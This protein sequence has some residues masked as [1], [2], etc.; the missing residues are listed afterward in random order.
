MSPSAAVSVRAN[1]DCEVCYTLS[2]EGVGGQ[3]PYTFDWQDGSHDAERTICPDQFGGALTLVVRD[4]L[5]ASS[6]PNTTQLE[7]GDAKCPTTPSTKLLSLSNPSFEGTVAYNTG[8]AG[9]FDAPPWSQCINPTE[10]NTPDVISDTGMQTSFSPAPKAN[11]GLTYLGLTEDEQASQALS[12]AV[13]AGSTVY[14]QLDLNRLDLTVGGAA[15]DTEQAF[16]ELWGGS[17]SDCVRRELLWKSPG[18]THNWVTFCVP[19]RPQQAMDNFIV[20]STSDGSLPTPTYV[21]VDHL[22]P[23]SQCP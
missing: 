13:P 11:D 21:L 8:G 14:L 19:L 15:P 16:V 10:T 7:P 12:E 18:L 3:P 20:R 5:G 9:E 6:A 4:A 17:A 22:V 1:G 23:V 2:A